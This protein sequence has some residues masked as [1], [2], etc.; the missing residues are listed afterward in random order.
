MISKTVYE[1]EIMQSSPD[2]RA[3]EIFRRLEACGKLHDRSVL[4]DA[5]R[6]RDA[7]LKELDG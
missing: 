6:R 2:N 5:I 1:L 4:D 3:I 7:A